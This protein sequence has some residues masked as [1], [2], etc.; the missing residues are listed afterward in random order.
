MLSRTLVAMNSS[1]SSGT[2]MGSRSAFL[3]RMAMRVSS[4]GRLDV[5]DE[6]PLEP[7][8]QAVLQ[9]GEALGRPVGRDARSGGW[10]RAGQLNVWKNSSLV[11]SLPSMNWMSSISRTSHSR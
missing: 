3:R 7:A 2:G 10:R 1:T 6:A 4:S 5:G 9:G 11:D 8:A